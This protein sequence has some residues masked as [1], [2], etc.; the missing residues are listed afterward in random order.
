MQ[1]CALF[2]P[3]FWWGLSSFGDEQASTLLY[4]SRIALLDSYIGEKNILKKHCKV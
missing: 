1:I 4:M 3:L 2:H